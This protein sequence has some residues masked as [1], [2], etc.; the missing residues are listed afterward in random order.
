MKTSRLQLASD[1]LQ[2]VSATQ[3]RSENILDELGLSSEVQAAIRGAEL[4]N[5]IQ[6]VAQTDNGLAITARN[7]VLFEGP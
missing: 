2:Q 6:D 7:Q 4:A 5:A 1:D 3:Q